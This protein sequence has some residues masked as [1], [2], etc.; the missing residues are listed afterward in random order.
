MLGRQSFL[1]RSIWLAGIDFV[2]IVLIEWVGCAEA[3]KAMAIYCPE[4][5]EI[6][7]INTFLATQKDLPEDQRQPIGP[8]EEFA[9]CIHEIPLIEK[10]LQGWRY[11]TEFNEKLNDV[12][13]DI[14][15][16][17]SACKELKGSLALIGA[18]SL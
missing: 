5:N 10:R 11:K 16:V 14:E 7:M 6:K 15:S 13:P 1:I 2:I 8:I 4:D 17:L 9:L 12:K 18:Q 3:I